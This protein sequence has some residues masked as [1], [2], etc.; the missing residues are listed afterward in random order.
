MK[1]I[2]AMDEENG[3]SKNG[4]IPWKNKTELA[5]FKKTTLHN[6]VL[7]GYNTYLSLGSKALPAR[8]NYVLTS[9]KFL[10][11]PDCKV[12]NDLKHV[13]NIEKDLN[14]KNEELFIIGGKKVYEELLQDCNELVISVIRGKYNCDLKLNLDLSNFNL[15]KE[16]RHN[17]FKVLYYKKKV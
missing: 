16:E 3:I 8:S 9:K 15:E 11:L 12:I 6:G 17:S 7:M 4:S 14:A 10:S 13:K 1:L 2:V 5:H